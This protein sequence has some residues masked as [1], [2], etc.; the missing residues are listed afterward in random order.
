MANRPRYNNDPFISGSVYHA[1]KEREENIIGKRI[2][3]A[4]GER[5]LSLAELSLLLNK[6]GLAIQRQG[7]SKWE[8]GLAVPNAY[9]LLALCHALEIEDGI[10]YFTGHPERQE[11]LNEAGLKKLRDYREDLIASGRY[12]PKISR[13]QNIIYLDMRVSTL[14]ASAGTGAFLED[15]NFELVSFPADQIPPKADFGV[16]VSGDSMEPV[17]HDGQIVWVQQCSHL[18]PGDVGLFLYDGD[19]YIK[20]YGEQ[21]PDEAQ[22]ESFIDSNGVLHMQPVLISYNRNYPPKPVSPQLSFVIAGKVLS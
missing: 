1:G 16:R 6:H 4:R 20:V 17:Y 12:T 22:Q 10:T 9:Q 14:P 19:G 13:E 15:E 5:N 18:S 11:Q 21:R 2:A 7:I 3:Q 8:N